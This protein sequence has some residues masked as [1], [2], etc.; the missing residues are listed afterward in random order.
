MKSDRIFVGTVV[1]IRGALPTFI[2]DVVLLETKHGH[3]VDIANY[4]FLDIPYLYL[5]DQYKSGGRFF[6][7]DSN[8]RG[9]CY[10]IEVAKGSL[11]PYETEKKH[12][13]LVK[14]RRKLRQ[15]NRNK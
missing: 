2:H 6:P 9:I 4:P 5:E 10:G 12:V 1:I 14:L 7:A 3:Y 11:E 15:Q 13:S 8:S